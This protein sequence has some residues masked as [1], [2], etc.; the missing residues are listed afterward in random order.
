MKKIR[1]GKTEIMATKTSFGALPIMRVSMSEAREILRYAY[2]SGINYYDTARQYTDSEEKI[3]YALSDVRDKIYIAT[4]S[5]KLTVAEMEKELHT[6]LKNLKTD[7][8]DVYQLHNPPFCP[9]PDGEDGIYDFLVKA[10]EAGKIRN[11]AITNHRLHVAKEAIES[12][13][14]SLLQF[15]HAYLST[16][17][18]IDVARL[19]VE[20]DMGF[21]AMKPFAGGALQHASAVYS[22]F[23]KAENVLPIYG[24]QKLEE[25]KEI[26]SFE[27][28]PPNED[29]VKAIIEKDRKELSGDFC[30][31]CGYCLPC[32]VDIDVAAVSRSY[33]NLRRMPAEMMITDAWAKMMED[34]KK[35]VNCGACVKR[36]PYDLNPPS[37]F[38]MLRV[39]YEEH[40]TKHM[41]KA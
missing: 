13:L 23:A 2:D 14:Y 10:K 36:C 20:A 34:T 11:I 3:G 28:N 41:A 33:H 29:E 21:V 31:N 17:V 12:G 22:F 19:S 37:R 25:L 39:D 40:Y 8:I 18:E 24:I 9:K 1:M 4:K 6:S 35:C 5:N 7:Y 30:R 15:P 27:E 38:E 16:E 32:P 26:L